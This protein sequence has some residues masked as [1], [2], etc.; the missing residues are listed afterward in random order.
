[1]STKTGQTM[2]REEIAWQNLLLV[3]PITALTGIDEG[4]ALL[5]SRSRASRL[6]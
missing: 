2:P 5:F 3:F 1:M 6:S 4:G